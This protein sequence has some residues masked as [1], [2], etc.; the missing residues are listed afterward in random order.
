[1]FPA[2]NPV[3]ALQ[4]AA[5]LQ[6][7]EPNPGRQAKWVAVSRSEKPGWK[8]GAGNR[9]GAERKVTADDQEQREP[10]PDGA[11][12]DQG[13]E[14]GGFGPLGDPVGRLTADSGERR[15]RRGLACALLLGLLEG[16]VDQTH[17]DWT[18][19]TELKRRWF[20]SG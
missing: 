4:S 15:Q 13:V 8:L 2:E 6:A 14:A 12:E 18:E 16:V 11:A 7:K 17:A 1:L 3:F 9:G 20:T 5:Q 19:L 10:G